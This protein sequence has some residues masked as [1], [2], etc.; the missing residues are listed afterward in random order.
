MFASGGEQQPWP[1]DGTTTE[2]PYVTLLQ[3]Q[4][5]TPVSVT[6]AATGTTYTMDGV[7][8]GTVVSIDAGSGQPVATL[9]TLPTSS[10]VFLTGNFRD[11]DDTGFME[12]TNALSTNDPAT[13]DLYILDARQSAS[14]ARVTNHL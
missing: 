11:G 12:A 13:R 5:L 4:N 1:D 9:G 8:G 7:S 14:L 2:T 10:A 3:V 6:D